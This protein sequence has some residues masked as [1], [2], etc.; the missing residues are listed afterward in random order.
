VAAL[1]A[2]TPLPELVLSGRLLEM[3]AECAAEVQAGLGRLGNVARLPNLP[4]AW[5]KHAAQ[6]AA[7]L[8]DGLAGGQQERLVEHLR[9]REAAMIDIPDLSLRAKR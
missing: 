4:G 2:V 8:A 6:G 5:V 9:L 3:E 1:Q 7:L